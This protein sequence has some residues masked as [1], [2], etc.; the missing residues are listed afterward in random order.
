MWNST[1]RATEKGTQYE[2]PELDAI[3]N[4]VGSMLELEEGA[5]EEPL[6]KDAE[7]DFHYSSYLNGITNGKYIHTIFE[8]LSEMIN[9]EPFKEAPFYK[10]AVLASLL[11]GLRE[12]F[13]ERLA[14]EEFPKKDAEDIWILYA[15]SRRRRNTPVWVDNEDKEAKPPALSK[16]N[17]EDWDWIL[18]EIHDEF[19]WDRDWELG[20]FSGTNF[21]LLERSVHFHRFKNIALPKHGL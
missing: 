10:E 18:E 13:L 8:I 1:S 4:Y 6:L 21:A 5:K 3:I 17:A 12:D 14:G 19:L 16:I 15:A 20:L 9:D 11:D 2:F 7:C